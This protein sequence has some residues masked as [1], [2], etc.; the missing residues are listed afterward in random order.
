MAMADTEP[1]EHTTA[2]IPELP[3]ALVIPEPVIAVGMAI[4]LIA[5]I[6]VSVTGLGGT[7]ALSICIAGLVVGAIGAALVGAQ[8]AAVRRG[9]RTAQ[10]GL[11]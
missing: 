9:D 10:R 1:R 5:T 3:R 11:R 8:R 2:Q 4:W 7:N 6:V